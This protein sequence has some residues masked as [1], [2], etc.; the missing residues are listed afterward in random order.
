MP[1]HVPVL[2]EEAV[3]LLVADAQGTFVDATLGHGGHAAAIVAA[4][5]GDAGRVIGLDCDPEAVERANAAPPAPAPRFQAARARFSEIDDALDGLGVA[6][7]DGLL[8]DLGLSSD[9]LD[10][11]ARGLAFSLDGPLDMR[12]DPSRPE[13]ADQLVRR[14]DERELARLLATY[15]ELP[16]AHAAARALRRAAEATR[17]LTTRA[18]REALAPLYRGPGRPRRLA[19]AFQALRVA[20][21]REQEELAAL[22]DVA[23]RRVAPGGT[24]VVI[25]YHSLEDRMVKHAMTPP[26]PLD[27]WA[28]PPESP[29]IP[30]T[31]KPI[32][33]SA[34]EV[35][36]NPRAASARLRAARRRGGSPC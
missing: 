15:G 17:P 16:R 31:R 5:S 12:L 28:A 32:R 26:R 22:L 34:D 13:T 20:V 27:A 21:N 11:P 30:L 18:A 7:V 25:A 8:A 24:L 35:A 36:E 19:Q 9:Q 10:D 1:G 3:R 4:L 2:R 6:T 23:A 29:W 33:P 14:L